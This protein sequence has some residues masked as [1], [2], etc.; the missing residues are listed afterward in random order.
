MFSLWV[1]QIAEDGLIHICTE[2][3]GML[4]S[5][6]DVY[7]IIIAKMSNIKLLYM[8]KTQNKIGNFDFIA[9]RHWCKIFCYRNLL[10]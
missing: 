7:L 6:S 9:I 8:E 3:I 4:V 5:V 10:I 2:D 1:A